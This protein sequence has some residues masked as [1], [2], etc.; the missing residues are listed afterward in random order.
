MTKISDLPDLTRYNLDCRFGENL[1]EIPV[2]AKSMLEYCKLGFAWIRQEM[3]QPETS[4]RVP[5]L[6]Q[7]LGRVAEKL[8]I[9][10]QTDEAMEMIETSLALA[11]IH[12][13]GP[14]V[15]VAQSLRRADILCAQK[16]F[17]NAESA[18]QKVLQ[19]CAAF[20]EALPWQHFALQNLGK[21]KLSEGQL[22]A[23]L[24][25]FEKALALRKILADTSL[26]ASTELAIATTQTR[27]SLQK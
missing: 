20:P 15:I 23:A 8:K 10:Q 19:I 18:Y 16:K 4:W 1:E 6:V 27:L 14:A 9:L 11:Q 26:L 5:T 2:D 13:L 17:R 7:T 24:E 25:L 3:E 22:T 21:L 12:N